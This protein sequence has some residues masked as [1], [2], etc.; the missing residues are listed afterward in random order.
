VVELPGTL[1]RVE[2]SDASVDGFV[3]QGAGFLGQSL[4]GINGDVWK[5]NADGVLLLN[6][7]GYPQVSS[8]KEIIGDRNPDY[9]VGLTNSFQ[10][11]N[12]NLAFL[13]DFRIGG[14]IYNATENAL[15]RSGLSTN[16]LDRGTTTIFDG[17]IESTGERNTQQVV[18]NQNYYQTILRGNGD[19]FVE[20]GSWY[21]LRYATLSYRVPKAL[22]SR[23]NIKG[24]EF[25]ATGRNLI[26]ITNYSGVDPEVSSGGAGVAG[27]GSMGMDNLGTPATK[28]VDFGL[29][30][31]F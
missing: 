25:Y 29:R 5:R 13:W 21:R 14:D 1:D 4:F 9:I 31:S 6:N 16:T 11:K 26:L 18:L 7:Q 22:L 2:Q 15:I 10:Y 19:L 24:L 28:G 20:D 17:I 27:T 12:F 23:A 8:I 30:L 3:A